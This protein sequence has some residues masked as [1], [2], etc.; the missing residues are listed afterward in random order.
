MQRKLASKTEN[1]AKV[2]NAKYPGDSLAMIIRRQG[3]LTL[4]TLLSSLQVRNDE[5]VY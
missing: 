3:L 2:I 4:Q 1:Y 5:E